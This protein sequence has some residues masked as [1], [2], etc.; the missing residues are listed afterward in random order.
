IPTDAVRRGASVVCRGKLEPVPEGFLLMAPRKLGAVW[1]S[2]ILSLPGKLRLAGEYFVKAHRE[3][4]DESVASFV[5]RRLGREAFERLVQPLVGGIYTADP[6]K[7]SLASTLPRFIE[8][9]RR[10]GGL[11]RA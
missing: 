2:P 3:G 5:R 4:G 1:R 11:I 9:E 7:L 6:E 8:M 10:H